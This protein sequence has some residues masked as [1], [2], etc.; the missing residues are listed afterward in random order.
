LY[1]AKYDLYYT[2]LLVTLTPLLVLGILILLSAALPSIGEIWGY[3]WKEATRPKL[4]A[5]AVLLGL[6]ISIRQIGAFAGGLVSLVMLYRGRGRAL[7]PLV[8]YWV[9]A[10][11]VSIVTWPYLWHDPYSRLIGSLFLAT[12]FP[13]HSTLFQGR[14]FGSG[15]LPWNYFPTL[16]GLQLT[17]TAL[18]LLMLGLGI[19]FWRF[20]KKGSTRFLLVVLGLWVGIP[21]AGQ[22]FF[23]MPVYGIRHLLF[24]F[25]PLFILVGVGFEA[26]SDRLR[27]IWAQIVLCGVILFPGIWAAIELHPY[28][29]IYFNTLAGGV[30]GAYGDFEMDRWC[31]SYRE[32]I[33]YV[34][35]IA[36][37]NSVVVVPQQTN[38]VVP[39]ARPGLRLMDLNQGMATANFVLSCIWRDAG[40]WSTKGFKKVYEVR[41]G[42]A[43]LTEVWQRQGKG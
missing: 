18:V 41:R 29:Y 3:S 4:L 26:V 12:E 20:T 38:Q 37:P 17:E 21:L 35:S 8:V 42:E 23:R 5:S 16:T 43:I 7:F 9:M 10:A 24:V 32:A 25:P 30:S 33:E 27:K 11:V 15:H 2:Y 22:M 13:G 34:N 6:T 1:L 36:E 31:I 28:E 40:D 19:V 14:D 39:F